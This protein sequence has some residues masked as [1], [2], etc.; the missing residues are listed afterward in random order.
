MRSKSFRVRLALAWALGLVVLVPAA[1][2]V[3]PGI[4]ELVGESDVWRVASV[5]GGWSLIVFA[6]LPKYFRPD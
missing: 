2:L 6:V 4:S 5:V 3:P 1:L